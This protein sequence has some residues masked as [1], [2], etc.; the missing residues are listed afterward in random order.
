MTLPVVSRALA[1]VAVYPPGATFGPRRLRDHEFVWVLQGS[2]DWSAGAERVHLE[3]GW[4]LLLRPGM[5]DRFD[6]DREQPTRHAFCHFTVPELGP[7]A[8]GRRLRPLTPGG[9]LESLCRYALALHFGR[10]ANAVDRLRD[11]LGLL[12]KVFDEGPM[13]EDDA[14]LAPLPAPL[15]RAIAYLNGEW[16]ANG[17]R[18][19]GLEEL[20]MAA[21][22]SPTHLSRLFRLHLGMGSAAVQERLRLARAA[23]LLRRSNLSIA[24]ISDTCGFANPYHFSH[25]FRVVAGVSP[26]AYRSSGEI[27][28]ELLL[29]GG[30]QRLG[31]LMWTVPDRSRPR[32]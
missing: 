24:A 4:L 22:V 23:T 20:G 16:S 31:A 30:L 5:R 2:A 18:A 10:S 3:P 28:G 9:P 25:R 21:A 26:S 1:G 8:P 14:A 29:E 11:V 32:S 12:L 6:W 13:P 27:P 17:P 7:P 19:I 15:E